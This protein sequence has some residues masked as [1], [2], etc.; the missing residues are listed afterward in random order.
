MGAT[1]KAASS[2]VTRRS[3]RQ[4]FVKRLRALADALEQGEPFRLSI[5]GERIVIPV[6]A[7]PSIEHE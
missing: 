3:P 1:K 4:H 2:D 5:A 6:D 7:V